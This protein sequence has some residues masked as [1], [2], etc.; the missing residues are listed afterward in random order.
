MSSSPP[1]DVSFDG[2]FFKKYRYQSVDTEKKKPV[3]RDTPL[4]IGSTLRVA[5]A[6]ASR[7]HPS[8]QDERI[9]L[10]QPLR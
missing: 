3:W 10:P 9:A 2:Y 1:I 7:S 4:L 5:K 6:S 8:H